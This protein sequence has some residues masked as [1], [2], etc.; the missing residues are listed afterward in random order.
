MTDREH[1]LNLI[2]AG[3]NNEEII[4]NFKARTR[5]NGW[6]VVDEKYKENFVHWANVALMKTEHK[7]RFQAE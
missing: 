3:K 5:E 7:D 2:K 6:P 1:L 4:E